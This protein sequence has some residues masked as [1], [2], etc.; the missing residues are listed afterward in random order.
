[1]G[2]GRYRWA[3]RLL[4]TAVATGAVSVLV[5]VLMPSTV[6]EIKRLLL[7]SAGSSEPAI[8]T[9]SLSALQIQPVRGGRLVPDERVGLSTLWEDRTLI[10][11]VTRRFG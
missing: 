10:L 7:V 6:P 8:S 5:P 4:Q 2:A 11:H 9:S 1:M 3:K